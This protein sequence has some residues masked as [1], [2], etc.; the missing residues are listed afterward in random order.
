MQKFMSLEE[1]LRTQE[2]EHKD[3]VHNLEKKSVLDKDRWAGCCRA[4]DP[5]TEAKYSQVSRPLTALPSIW[6]GGNHASSLMPRLA[7]P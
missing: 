7:T 6:A 3:Y 2:N 1:Q 4:R 5:L